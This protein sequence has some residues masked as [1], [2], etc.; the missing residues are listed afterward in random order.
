[1]R[2]HRSTWL[3]GA[4]ALAAVALGWS[5]GSVEAQFLAEQEAAMGMAD[6]LNSQ[7]VAPTGGFDPI[8]RAQAV[9]D[10]TAPGDGD[11]V[12]QQPE[13]QPMPDMT[14]PGF[15]DFGQ[16]GE[17]IETVVE[18]EV[19]RITVITGTRVFDSIS[20]RLIDDA[21]RMQVPET[22]RD[23]YYNDGT[24]GDMDPTDGI[25]TLV[26]EVDNVIG[27][28]NQRIK[29]Q[30]I[31]ALSAAN[32]MSP[33]QFYGHTLMS[34][35]R[36]EMTS[37]DLA[38]KLVPNPDGPGLVL[39]QVPIEE[40][41]VVPK[42]REKLAEKDSQIKDQWTDRF[43][44]DFRIDRDDLRSEFYRMHIPRPP[45]PPAV[46]PPAGWQPFTGVSDQQTPG[47]M[48]GGGMGLGAGLPGV[49]Y[50]GGGYPGGGAMPM[51]GGRY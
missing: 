24:H 26:D 10:G 4:C 49:G 19:P 44:M 47:G 34:N 9:A 28:A 5:G 45:V 30:L 33:L 3:R 11:F 16:F 32:N 39:R 40:P 21:V 43:L 2:L 6:T 41:L 50:P 23:K 15:D 17:M 37:R 20:G 29:E 27:H 22:E 13:F 42:Y 48:P 25:Y 38:W 31:H 35:E 12:G 18:Q 36:H 1:M 51:G 14:I 7:P 8:G 46:R